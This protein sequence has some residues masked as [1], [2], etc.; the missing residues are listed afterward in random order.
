MDTAAQ[1]VVATP[2]G[3]DAGA[4]TADLYDWQ[5]AMAASDGFRMFADALDD[6]G[7]LRQDATGQVICEHHE[8]WTLLREPDAELVSAKHRELA[9]G[10]WT[11]IKQLVDNGGLAHLFGRWL[12]LDEKPGVRL[13]TCAAL[14]AGP[15]R[16]LALT[17]QLLRDEIAGRD[18]DATVLTSIDETTK[19]FAKE[20]LFH[21]NGLPEEW[22]A[23]AD[24]TVRS[25][26]VLGG[27]TSK[28]RTLLTKLVIDEGRPHRNVIGHAA[29]TM[30]A[31]PA[32]ER[33]GQS[34]AF[35][36][37]AWEAVLQLFRAR[38]RARGPKPHGDL[39]V[40][41]ATSSRSGG[42]TT[43][44]VTRATLEGRTIDLQDIELAIRVALRN[45]QGYMPLAIPAQLTRLGVKMARGGCSDTSIARAERLRSD[46]KRYRR[47]RGSGTPG[48]IAEWRSLER[49]LMRIADIATQS[50]RAPHGTWGS[51]L[52]SDL[53]QRLGNDSAPDWLDGLDTELAL[54]AICDLTDRCEVWF[55]P[56]FDVRSELV[57]LRAERKASQ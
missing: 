34:E 54:G 8:D 51:P 45:P 33:M 43:D 24:A 28:A 56:H 4:R 27:H 3:D 20:L 47:E 23:P 49:H 15:A 9:S 36:T 41:L 30:F 55:S 1:V 17:T 38:M 52:W 40:V 5:A 19:H 21:R 50:A 11:T 10:A 42:A 57:R 7:H 16:T 48:A 32:L 46:F 53:A 26:V 2:V 39:P 31:R 6:Q 12:A 25:Y 18:L 14:A 44:F 35:A 37:A 22:R 13:V 29:P